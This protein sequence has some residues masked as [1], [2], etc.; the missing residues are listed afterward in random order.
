MRLI[1]TGEFVIVEFM[2]HCLAIRGRSL[3]V[4]IKV[5]G[6]VYEDSKKYIIVS[7]WISNNNIDDCGNDNYTMIKHPG[8]KI[9]KVKLKWKS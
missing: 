9:R 8:M 2:D 7:P 1:K 6:W 5:A 4:P 3:P